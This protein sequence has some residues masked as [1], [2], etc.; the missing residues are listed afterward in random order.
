LHRE[1][2]PLLEIPHQ[3]SD[4]ELYN[5]GEKWLP[6]GRVRERYDRSDTTIDRWLADDTSGFPKP[7]Y[8]SKRRYWRLSDLLRWEQQRALTTAQQQ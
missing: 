2:I 7:T 6:I 8:F 3:H 5:A 1:I 4:A